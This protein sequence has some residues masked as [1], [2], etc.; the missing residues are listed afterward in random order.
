MKRVT[1]D[2]IASVTSRLALD[3][4]AV[5]GEEIPAVAGTVVAA[6]V[7]NAKTSYNTLEDVHGRMVLLHPTSSPARSGTATRSTAMR[8]ACRTRSRWGTSSGS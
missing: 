4:N 1:L 8:A 2:K 3:P 5:L 7:L 6:R